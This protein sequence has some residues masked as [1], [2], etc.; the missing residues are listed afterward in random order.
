MRYG[1]DPVVT[2]HKTGIPADEIARGLWPAIQEFCEKERE[3]W[4]VARR[5]TNNN[6]LTVLVR[7]KSALRAAIEQVLPCGTTS[8]AMWRTPKTLAELG[9][10]VISGCCSAAEQSAFIAGVLTAGEVDAIVTRAVSREKENGLVWDVGNSLA[11]TMI[12]LKRLRGL[13]QHI[14]DIECFDTP[15]DIVETGVWRGGACIFA[16]WF[17]RELGNPHGRVVM[18]CDSFQGLPPPEPAKYPVDTGD[19]HHTFAALAISLETVQ[20]NAAH[21]GVA[22]TWV[23]GWFEVT[24]PCLAETLSSV[25]ILRLD[26]DMYSSTTQSVVALEPLV[27]HNGFVIVDDWALPGAKAAIKDYRSAKGIADPIVDY[28]DGIAMFWRKGAA[29]PAS[30]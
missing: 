22:V 29:S 15:G 6:G 20:A 25:A 3:R 4:Y 24:C 13:A 28:G 10:R 21:F 23:K 18:G 30:E 14:L 8:L 19:K 5:Y 12:G 2:A 9:A 27:P 26:G 16:S 1:W 11:L 17:L 7:R